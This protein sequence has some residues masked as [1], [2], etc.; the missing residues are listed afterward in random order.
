MRAR[1]AVVVA[2]FAVGCT[3][4]AQQ[5]SGRP[6]GAIN[7]DTV[8][9]VALPARPPAPELAGETTTGGPLDGGIAEG[10]P[11]VVNFWASWCGP[12][13][14]EM[15]ELVATHAD[16]GDDVGFVGV[17]VRDSATNARAFERDLGVTYPSVF[18]PS[19]ELAGSFGGIAPAALPSTVLLDADRR[20]AVRLFGAVTAATL[21]PYLDALLAE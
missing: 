5:Q 16:Y 14:T 21:R 3:L 11:V 2:L 8:P 4:S 19:V 13:A 15:P 9:L 1:L 7:I 20:V 12:C 6:A 17:N 18:D 10:R